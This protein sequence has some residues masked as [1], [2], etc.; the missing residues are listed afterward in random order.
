VG[1]KPVSTKEITNT[2]IS[3]KEINSHGY[4]EVSTQLL[5]ISAPY[6]CSPKTNIKP[7]H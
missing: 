3:L 1:L 6:I 5:K 2:I 4:E 7:Y